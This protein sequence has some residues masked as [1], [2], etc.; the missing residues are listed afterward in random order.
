MRVVREACARGDRDAVADRR[1]LRDVAIRSDANAISEDAA[2]LDDRVVPDAAIGSN[3][4]VLADE[5]VPTG[6][7]VISCSNTRINRRSSDKTVCRSAIS[8]EI[9]MAV[10][11]D[12]FMRH[13]DRWSGYFRRP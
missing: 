8:M 4:R 1:E 10:S 11:G 13:A 2:A 9:S 12:C 7:E 3:H 5:H 6:L